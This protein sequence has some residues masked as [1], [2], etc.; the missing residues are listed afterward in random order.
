MMMWGDGDD[1]VF[2]ITSLSSL[3]PRV[4]PSLIFQA[5]V[6]GWDGD[7]DNRDVPRA[8]GAPPY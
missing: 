7:R 5:C 4:A 1:L 8:E 2:S 6:P 3:S